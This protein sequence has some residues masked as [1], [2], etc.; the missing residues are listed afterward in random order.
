MLAPPIMNMII[1]KYSL[2]QAL[3][4][5]RRCFCIFMNWTLLA[6]CDVMGGHMT[7]IFGSHIQDIKVKLHPNLGYVH[8]MVAEIFWISIFNKKALLDPGLN[9]P[10]YPSTAAHIQIYSYFNAYT[11][12]PLINLLKT[13]RTSSPLTQQHSSKFIVRY[14]KVLFS[15]KKGLMAGLSST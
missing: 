3:T 9:S 8:K 6:H 11:Y 15:G 5:L 1:A 12:W 10:E 14:S 13:R 7:T 4:P 2:T